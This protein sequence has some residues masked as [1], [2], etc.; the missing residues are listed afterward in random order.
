MRQ[1]IDG[2]GLRWP[3][4]WL[5][6][7]TSHRSRRKPSRVKRWS[8][9]AR[10]IVD[11]CHDRALGLLRDHRAQLDRLASTLLARETLGEAEAYEVAGVAE[12]VRR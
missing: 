6:V 11:Q 4:S 8:P 12:R 10:A 5:S 7:S 1:P 2:V 3:S 9:V